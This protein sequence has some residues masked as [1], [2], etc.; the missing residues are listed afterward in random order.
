[1]KKFTTQTKTIDIT[2]GQIIQKYLLCKY[3]SGPNIFGLASYDMENAIKN[4]FAPSGDTEYSVYEKEF[5]LAREEIY[6]Y[7]KLY[8]ENGKFISNGLSIR[9]A[10]ISRLFRGLDAN[11]FSSLI[12]S[13]DVFFDDSFE[14][15]SIIINNYLE[16][17]FS[18][19][20]NPNKKKKF[21]LVGISTDY[22]LPIDSTARSINTNGARS[23]NN[24]CPQT[25]FEKASKKNAAV[26]QLLAFTSL[27]FPS[28]VGA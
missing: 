20:R 19:K 6:I 25:M 10:R 4:S 28:S 18:I 16:I 12:K 26:H 11:V 24:R 23:R 21:Q 15:G 2:I 17:R 27:K 14:C 5:R 3:L 22:E 1:M 8:Y 13:F 9:G 7:L